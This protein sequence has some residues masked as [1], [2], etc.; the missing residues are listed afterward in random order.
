[1]TLGAEPLL[2]HI[3]LRGPDLLK[4]ISLGPLR[5]PFFCQQHHLLLWKPSLNIPVSQ[6]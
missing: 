2:S 4:G 6:Y 5:I 3:Y 1:M